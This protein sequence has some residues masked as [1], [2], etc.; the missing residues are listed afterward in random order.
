GGPTAPLV[1]G[2]DGPLAIAYVDNGIE[3]LAWSS[4]GTS[5]DGGSVILM[6]LVSGT[7][8]SLDSMIS[9]PYGVAL[10]DA[11]AYFA[12]EF[13]S[14]AQIDDAPLGLGSPHNLVLATSYTR[15]ACVA[16]NADSVFFT[17]MNLTTGGGLVAIPITGGP[18]VTL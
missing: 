12:S 7:V 3:Y 2:L 18:P 6:Q 16:V 11:H 4:A 5:P 15:P 13:E 9:R 17:A 8:F 10:D 14:V 1:G